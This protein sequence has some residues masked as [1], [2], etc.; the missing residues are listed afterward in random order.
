M[1]II[2]HTNKL[3]NIENKLSSPN[4]LSRQK[5]KDF[6]FPSMYEMHMLDHFASSKRDP[7]R[8]LRSLHQIQ[9]FLEMK[10]K[11]ASMT[12][13]FTSPYLKAKKF[14]YTFKGSE[15]IFHNHL[16]KSGTLNLS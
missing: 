6:P 15:V 9:S 2:L 12:L 4:H 3:G 11:V 16:L 14:D 5:S 13:A 8:F 7:Q 10:D 1:S